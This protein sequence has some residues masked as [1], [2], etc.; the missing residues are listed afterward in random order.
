MYLLDTNVISEARRGSLPALSWLRRVDPLSVHLS[1]L[2]LGEIM[3][4]IAL[5]QKADPKTAGHLAEWLR[6]LRHDHADRILPVTDPIS[7]EWGRIAATAIVHDLILVTRNVKDFDDT[8]A[9]FVNPWDA[10]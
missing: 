6:K 7:V 4:G 10:D 5:K 2:T 3:R 8:G 9:S 1:T